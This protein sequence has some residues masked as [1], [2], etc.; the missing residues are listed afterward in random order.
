MNDDVI[1]LGEQS[2]TR[3]ELEK[4]LPQGMQLVDTDTWVPRAELEK[5]RADR[6]IDLALTRRGARNLTAARA[7]MPEGP[8]TT[9]EICAAVEQLKAEND[10]LFRAETL[11]ASGSPLTPRPAVDPDKMSDAEYYA[12]RRTIKNQF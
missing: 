2:Y 9:E 1:S 10:W 12:Y 11:R 8:R 4:L 6:E 7:L 3:Q 5:A